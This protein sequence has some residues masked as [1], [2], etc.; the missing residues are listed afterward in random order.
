M[1]YK[2]I[3]KIQFPTYIALSGRKPFKACLGKEL[4]WNMFYFS[5]IPREFKLNN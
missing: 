2:N 1:K 5:L 3:L 4:K